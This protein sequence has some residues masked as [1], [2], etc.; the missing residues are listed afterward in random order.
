[1][2]KSRVS[3]NTAPMGILRAL[4][5]AAVTAI[6]VA[7]PASGGDAA[8]TEVSVTRDVTYGTAGGERLVLDVYAPVGRRAGRPAAVLVH[9]G[10][11][12]V[13]DKRTLRDRALT[14]AARGWVAFS[15]NYRLGAAPPRTDGAPPSLPAPVADVVT[16]VEWIRANAAVY[17]VDPARMAALGDSAG[18]TLVAMLA[19]LGEGPRDRGSRVLAAASW[20]GPMDFATLADGR[21]LTEL[22]KDSRHVLGCDPAACPVQAAHASPVAHVDPTDGAMLLATSTDELVALGQASA[23]HDALGRAGVERTLLVFRGTRHGRHHAADSW[24]PTLRFLEEAVGLR[25]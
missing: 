10:G 23:M 7:A 12:R 2:V 13:G 18:G 15:V 17:G 24:G 3:S 8:L 5:L 25:R 19:T 20:S 21:E 22:P 11:F 14:L 4:A 6:L 1:M 16:A 9:G